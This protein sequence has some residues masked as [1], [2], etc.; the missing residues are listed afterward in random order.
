MNKLIE[1]DNTLGTKFNFAFN[2]FSFL[3][4]IEY[5]E[6][7][8]NNDFL[9][10]SLMK[11]Q[12]DGF[13]NRTN[14]TLI[15]TEIITSFI[16]KDTTD[17]LS[18]TINFAVE[19]FNANKNKYNNSDQEEMKKRIINL[20]IQLGDYLRYYSLNYFDLLKYIRYQN[21]ISQGNDY[22]KFNEFEQ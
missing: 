18:E 9:N 1:I 5:I 4:F 14:N 3:T 15:N 22:I 11:D 2:N 8:T 21:Y 16:K 10:F 19:H 12:F 17:K 20:T 6:E 7:Q 13:K